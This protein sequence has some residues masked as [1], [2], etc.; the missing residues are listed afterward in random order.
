MRQL[1]FEYLKAESDENH[2]LV[3][4]IIVKVILSQAAKKSFHKKPTKKPNTTLELLGAEERA[5]C[6]QSGLLATGPV[7]SHLA[8]KGFLHRSSGHLLALE[9]KREMKRV[10]EML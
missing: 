4:K 8:R 7:L 10:V 2:R 9:E 1:K 3:S 5:V 6:V